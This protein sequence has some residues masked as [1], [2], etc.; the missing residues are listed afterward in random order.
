MIFKG[1]QIF[2]KANATKDGRAIQQKQGKVKQKQSKSNFNPSRTIRAA[3][4]R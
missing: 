2:I 3:Q 4:K 1:G